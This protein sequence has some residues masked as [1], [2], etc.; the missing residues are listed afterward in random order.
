[1]LKKRLIGIIVVKDGW[2]V[3]SIGYNRYLPMGKPEIVAENLDR[4]GVDEI[5]VLAIDRSRNNLGP[6]LDL[7][8]RL[9]GLGLFTPLAYGGGIRSVED[10]AS[11]VQAAADRLCLDGL[12]HSNPDEVRRI[13]ALVGSQAVIGSLPLGFTDGALV[14]RNYLT[15]IDKPLDSQIFSLFSDRI[16]SEAL[17]ID[18]RNEGHDNAFNASIVRQFPMRDIPLIA[19]G[20]I[21]RVEQMASLYDVPQVVAVAVGNFLSYRE[22]VVQGFKTNLLGQPIRAARFASGV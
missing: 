10:A 9:G 22:H 20:G 4:W 8:K 3:Q 7:L 13:A 21:S 2:A 12:L 16:V 17:L 11:V 5:L 14:W 1:M 19:F 15:R 6:D 18:W